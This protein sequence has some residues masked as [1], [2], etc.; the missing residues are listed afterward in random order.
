M[1]VLRL[2]IACMCV[3]LAEYSLAANS[4]HVYMV[5]KNKITG[6]TYTQVV[7]FKSDEITTLE[8]CNTEIEYGLSSG[9]RIYT[10]LLRK[11]KGFDYSTHYSCAESDQVFTKWI[12]EYSA[13]RV[14]YLVSNKEA[15]LMIKPQTSYAACLGIVRTAQKEETNELFCGQSSQ[16]IIE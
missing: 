5:A 2:A 7:F 8:E 16:K 12:G 9:W 4:S 6:T 11:V 1:K 10:H 13:R 3:L 14:I 15:H